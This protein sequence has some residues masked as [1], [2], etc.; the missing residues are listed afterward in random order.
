MKIISNHADP[1]SQVKT[2]PHIDSIEEAETLG[3]IIKLANK[4]DAI[5]HH[6]IRTLT[7]LIL[8]IQPEEVDEALRIILAEIM[9]KVKT[10]YAYC[11]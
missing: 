3:H 7:Q 10:Q 9:Y 2:S 11:E 4:T 1:S 6:E 8:R 5:E